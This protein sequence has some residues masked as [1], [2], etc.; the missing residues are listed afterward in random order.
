MLHE[1]IGENGTSLEHLSDAV[2][3]LRAGLGGLEGGARLRGP[4]R[5]T[6]GAGVIDNDRWF[7][8][9]WDDPTGGEMTAEEEAARQEDVVMERLEELVRR[10]VSSFYLSR[11][12]G[13][14]IESSLL[15]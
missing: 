8:G 4:R 13:F 12:F 11:G 15:N 10:H 5:D 6:A 2:E 14:V 1:A 7:A 9:V 3:A